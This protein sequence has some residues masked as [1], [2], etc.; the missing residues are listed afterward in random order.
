MFGLN[1]RFI[2]I[3]YSPSHAHHSRAKL[4][5]YTRCPKKKSA[6]GKH[7]EIS[8]HGFKMCFLYVKMDKLDPNPSRPSLQGVSVKVPFSPSMS[9]GLNLI[10]YC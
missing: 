2:F 9:Q 10:K 4:I 1:I 3:E 6:L 7:L 5:I 8:T